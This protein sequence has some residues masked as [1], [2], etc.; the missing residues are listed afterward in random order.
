MSSDEWVENQLRQVPVPG[1]LLKRL[2]T[3]ALA[4]DDALD[5]ALR[6]VPMPAGLVQELAKLA[7][8][9]DKAIDREVA[10][11]PA[12]PN[13]LDKLRTIPAY[14]SPH[15]EA[16]LRD[17]PV[18]DGLLSRLSA[19]A[20][21]VKPSTTLVRDRS[22]H[23]WWRFAAAACLLIL[24]GTSYLAAFASFFSIAYRP[25]PDDV[26]SLAIVN[27]PLAIDGDQAPLIEIGPTPIPTEE[28]AGSRTVEAFWKFVIDGIRQA[29]LPRNVTAQLA[30]VAKHW[31]REDTSVDAWQGLGGRPDAAPTLQRVEDFARGGFTPSYLDPDLIL[32]QMNK[33]AHPFVDPSTDEHLQERIVP[34][35]TTTESFDWATQY[36]DEM[37]G[38]ADRRILEEALA[39]RVRVEE[40]LA[41]IHYPVAPAKDDTLA[42]RAVGGP[43]PW[44]DAGHR[45]LQ[46]IVIAGQHS[47]PA[48]NSQRMI[49]RDVR[50]TIHFDPS[51]VAEYRLMGHETVSS[52]GLLDTPVEID[53]HA[54]QVATGLF[55]L[56][57]RSSDVNRIGSAKLTWYDH[58]RRERFEL[59]Q[60]ISRLQFATTFAESAPSLQTAAQVAEA[61]E[62]LR[63]SPFVT[64]SKSSL[65]AVREMA[66]RIDETMRYEESFQQFVLFLD[67]AVRAGLR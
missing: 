44:G 32:F 57:L 19:I 59:I 8:Y 29:P 61:A 64:R 11:V 30:D 14:S 36:L 7:T 65:A 60:P 13:L 55:E 56:Q 3:V 15:I 43:S 58:D 18:P 47:D 22:A 23:Q 27:R 66:G 5:A 35:G 50:L 4:D 48:A 33:H 37:A 20:P 2:R 41:A 46:V 67:E 24:I 10:K 31:Q 34:L 16:M 42:V 9:P 12:N 21:P 45:L 6:D 1:G 26:V 63:R 54:G 25:L 51:A 62:I 53:L 39:D 40:F 52:V 38:I 49:A 17:V 28:V